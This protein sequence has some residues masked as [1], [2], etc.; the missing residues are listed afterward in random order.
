MKR[1]ALRLR[2]H[3]ALSRAAPVLALLGIAAC[4]F[5]NTLDVCERE[6]P[7]AEGPLTDARDGIELSGP[8]A[9][10]AM[11]SAGAL[12]FFIRTVVEGTNIRASLLASRVETDGGRSRA[13]QRFP[14]A[15]PYASTDGL[16]SLVNAAAAAPAV[17]AA[18]SFG[19]VAVAR[20]V[21]GTAGNF[22]ESRLVGVTFDGEGCPVLE[23]SDGSPAL[24]DLGDETA[25]EGVLGSP[26]VLRLDDNRFVVAW[27]S[28]SLIDFRAQARL[29]ELRRGL[30]PVLSPIVTLDR[31][32]ISALAMAALGDGRLAFAWQR[33]AFPDAFILLEIWSDT[34]EPIPALERQFLARVEAVTMLGDDARITLGFDGGQLLAAW[35]AREPGAALRINARFRGLNGEPFVSVDAPDGL[36]FRPSDNIA[37]EELNP[38]IAAV[39]GGGLVLAWEEHGLPSSPS[40]RIRAAAFDAA[41]RRQFLN[42]SCGTAPI[43]VSTAGDRI[44]IEP[45]LVFVG[46]RTLVSTWSA[47]ERDSPAGQVQARVFAPE[48]LFPID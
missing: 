25:G 44:F 45:A 5:T 19:L 39:P 22:V 4:T 17:A 36:A 16:T 32:P 9:A 7:P 33:A 21:S 23:R 6:P 11:P 47:F 10:V 24:F 37:G 14:L 38:V 12:V 46:E 43:A 40:D 34:L 2:V 13:C 28:G 30:A 35:T 41:G 29:V 18:T 8:R 48:Q 3:L 42:A 31:G 26:T 20:V 1:L 27:A 15:V